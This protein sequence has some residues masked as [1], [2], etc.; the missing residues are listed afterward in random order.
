MSFKEMRRLLSDD[1]G[2]E[3]D[4][5]QAKVKMLELDRNK[6]YENGLELE[7]ERD[8]LKERV[9]E[10]EAENQRLKAQLEREGGDVK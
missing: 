1:M 8:S 9:K 5:L 6:F 7:S 2:Q 10:L 4:R 3:R